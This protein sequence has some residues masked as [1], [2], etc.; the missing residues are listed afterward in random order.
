MRVE[1]PWVKAQD[2]HRSV[3]GRP[4]WQ[5]C[6]RDDTLI[7]TTVPK[8][9]SRDSAHCEGIWWME[10]IRPPIPAAVM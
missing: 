5:Y 8:G 1:T 10:I 3:E 9:F 4:V 2:I 7:I 6:E